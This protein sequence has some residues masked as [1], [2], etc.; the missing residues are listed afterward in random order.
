MDNHHAFFD[1]LSITITLNEGVHDVDS[2]DIHLF[3]FL[4]CLLSIYK[5]KA[6][7]EWGYS[8]AVTQYGYPYA[9]EITNSLDLLK[10]IGHIESNHLIIQPTEQGKRK[11]EFLRK[12]TLY[13]ERE[14]FLVG[15]TGTALALP[16]GSIYSAISE[17]TEIRN[18]VTL[19]Q[20]RQLLSEVGQKMLYEQF[21]ELSAQIGINAKDLMLPA[22]IWL[23][24]FAN[25]NNPMLRQLS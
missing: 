13:T 7:S 11:Y 9:G 21:K 6:A 24:Y 14:K 19:T 22:F 8:F 10:K 4:A 20:N 15:A 25:I 23:S 5:G 12:F 18:A 17:G 1:S 16:L 3:A 2:P